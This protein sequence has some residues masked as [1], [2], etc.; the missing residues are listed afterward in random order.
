MFES[1]N[2]WEHKDTNILLDHVERYRSDIDYKN[3]G[4]EN[5]YVG[6]LT[7]VYNKGQKKRFIESKTIKG[8]K[9]TLYYMGEY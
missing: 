3:Y 6:L 9:E 8:G 2:G 1:V 5:M 4:V 7:G